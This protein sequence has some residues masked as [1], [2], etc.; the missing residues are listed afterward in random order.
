MRTE[1]SAWFCV[2]TLNKQER[3]AAGNLR[4]V[5]GVEVF[6]PRF[7][8]RQLVGERVMRVT[9]SLFPNYLFA[10]FAFPGNLN[11][12]RYTAGVRDVVHF[13]DRWP[14]VPDAIVEELQTALNGEFAEL[15]D[16]LLVGEEVFIAAGACFGQAATV[17][18]VMPA[19][20]RIQVLFEILGRTVALEL[21][22]DQ[23]VRA[24]TRPP[25]LV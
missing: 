12:V 16:A 24:A 14:T 22:L 18:S 23:V 25:C 9:E 8:T 4:Q 20:R 1:D 15:A 17:H 6:H 3:A 5:N 11:E 7:S 19:R 13:S 21:S 10:R 2:Q